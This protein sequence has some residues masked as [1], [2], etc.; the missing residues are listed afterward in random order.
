MRKGTC[1]V[2]VIQARSLSIC[3]SSGARSGR[4]AARSQKTLA[5]R[6]S[7][8]RRRRSAITQ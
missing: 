5:M 2:K 4:K 3:V 8:G 7:V 1:M 6:K